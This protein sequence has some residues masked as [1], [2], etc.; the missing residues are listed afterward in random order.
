MLQALEG[1]VKGLLDAVSADNRAPP[2]HP[3]AAWTRDI[4]QRLCDLGR[5]W[6]CDISATGYEGAHLNHWLLDVVLSQGRRDELLDVLLVMGLPDDLQHGA[7]PPFTGVTVEID[8]FALG[9]HLTNVAH[10]IQS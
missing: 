1:E 6:G 4:K 3:N 10:R 5:E 8:S 2:V 9:V 7:G